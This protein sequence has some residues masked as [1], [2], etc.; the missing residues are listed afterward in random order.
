MDNPSHS[1]WVFMDAGDTFIYG[2][3][4]LYDAVQDCWKQEN[5]TI[6][7]EKI[8]AAVQEYLKNNP[9]HETYTQLRFESYMRSMYT[10]TLTT[11]HFPGDVN[12][13]TDFLWREWTAGRRLRLF[14]DTLF[15]LQA[16]KQAG[17]HL[18]VITNWDTSFE[19][20]LK[21][22][23]A[24][25]Y[26]EI[27]VVSCIEEMEK[28]DLRIFQYALQRANTQA[29]GCWYLGDSM[30]N[31]IVPAKKLGMKTIHVDYYL[32]RDAKNCADYNVPCLSLAAGIIL[33][34]GNIPEWL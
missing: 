26:F 21:R 3:P 32:K 9:R 4:T 28:P 22:L 6:H 7:T 29:E 12:T 31:D 13:Y 11:L 17:F 19:K 25:G 30:E 5:E 15:A 8:S 24:S 14:D 33:M 23:G 27:I 1:N 18:G 2:Y 20:T 34:N 10:H 16:L